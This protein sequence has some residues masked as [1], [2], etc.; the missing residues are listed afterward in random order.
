[1]EVSYPVGMGETPEPFGRSNPIAD[2]VSN[3]LLEGALR[4]LERRTLNR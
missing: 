2:V 4:N 1:M 3:S